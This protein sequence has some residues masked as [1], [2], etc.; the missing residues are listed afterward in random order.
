MKNCKSFPHRVPMLRYGKLLLLAGLFFFSS[1]RKDNDL[2]V[3]EG[4]PANPVSNLSS[5]RSSGLEGQV[6]DYT[7]WI[8]NN[9]VPVVKDQ[10]VYDEILAGNY[11]S[12]KVQTKMVALGFINF[13][14]FSGKLLAKGSAVNAALHS[15]AL[16][17]ETMLEILTKHL[18]EIDLN[19]L[20]SHGGSST[21]TP[22]YDQLITNL[23]IVGAEIALAAAGG[24]WAAI[25]VGLVGTAAAYISF[26]NCLDENYPQG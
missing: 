20:A 2:L 14:D 9:L 22:C 25:G 6:V 19:V 12:S 3:S 8:L 10:A 21:G 16:T 23:A 13:S 18:S 5:E 4:Y 26:K 11:S 1:C 24:P 17:K 15:G 7:Q